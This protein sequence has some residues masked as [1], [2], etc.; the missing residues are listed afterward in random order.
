MNCHSFTMQG[1]R[2]PW[3]QDV[4]TWVGV[5]IPAC[6]TVCGVFAAKEDADPR[7]WGGVLG[8]GILLLGVQFVLIAREYKLL[9]F[10]PRVEE[11]RAGNEHGGEAH[12]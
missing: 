3:Y 12:V 10:T 2:T 5:A 4:K 8:V 6:F 9:C 7:I 11:A 1:S